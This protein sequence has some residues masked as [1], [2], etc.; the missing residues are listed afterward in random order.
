MPTLVELHLQTGKKYID[1]ASSIYRNLNIYFNNVSKF[2]EKSDLYKLQIP[3][4]LLFCCRGSIQIS[5]EN[6]EGFLQLLREL[7]AEAICFECDG[8]T[9]SD[10]GGALQPTAW[11]AEYLEREDVSIKGGER[12]TYWTTVFKELQQKL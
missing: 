7:P 6:I 1:F 8:E 11:L 5:A 10:H 12:R 9:V 4:L 3:K 2:S